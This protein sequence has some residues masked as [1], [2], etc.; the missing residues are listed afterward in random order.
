MTLE[1]SRRILEKSLNIM[2]IRR[3]GADVF[4]ADGRTDM[5][6]VIV[7][8]CNFANAPTVNGPQL[9]STHHNR[10]KRILRSDQTTDWET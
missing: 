1:F 8:F 3:V 2:K 9:P 10:N 6:K 5:T 4:H 7:A